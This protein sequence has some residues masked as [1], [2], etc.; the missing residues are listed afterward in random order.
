MYNLSITNEGKMNEMK[1]VNAVDN[2]LKA[3]YSL[4]EKYAILEDLVR[5]VAEYHLQG[6]IVHGEPGI[7]KTFVTERGL[8]IHDKREVIKKTGH[9]TPLDVFNQLSNFPDRKHLHLFD[10]CDETFQNPSA[11]NLIK[12][13]MDTREPRIV[14]WGSTSAKASCSEFVFNGSVIIITNESVKD[15]PHYRALLDRFHHYEFTLST[16]ERIMKIQEVAAASPNPKAMEVADW[17]FDNAVTL[18]RE[19]ISLRT[20]VKL[21]DLTETSPKNWQKLATACGF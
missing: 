7:G 18:G 16:P 6:L 4:S 2:P 9:C 17:I 10:D 14:C 19:K 12:A 13:A 21:L 20:F 15:N 11:M 1:Q 8:K 3:A 5:G